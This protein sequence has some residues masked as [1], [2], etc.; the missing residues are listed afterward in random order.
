MIKF[1][2]S[3][4]AHPRP[5]RAHWP[6]PPASPSNQLTRQG[7][8]RPGCRIERAVRFATVPSQIDAFIGNRPASSLTRWQNNAQETL[9][10][11]LCSGAQELRPLAPGLLAE[12]ANQLNF[13]D[14][15]RNRFLPSLPCPD[16][17]LR[18]ERIGGIRFDPAS[19]LH[20]TPLRGS[21]IQ[22][23]RFTE[24][25]HLCGH[26]PLSN[27]RQDSTFRTESADRRKTR[28]FRFPSACQARFGKRSPFAQNC[29]QVAFI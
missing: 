1:S 29:E 27:D 12:S 16:T 5:N 22:R 26:F 20:E 25:S 17:R 11:S 13:S 6:E 10:C 2:S 21:L 4:L 23:L 15:L 28:F 9:I 14:Q 3:S 7:D 8:P 19:R 24:F 18:R